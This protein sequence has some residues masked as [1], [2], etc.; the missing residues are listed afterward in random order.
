VIHL[1][2]SSTRSNSTNVN[3]K[4][5]IFVFV[6]R[7]KSW[8]IHSPIS[9]LPTSR[10]QLID[11]RALNTRPEFILNL[12]IRTSCQQQISHEDNNELKSGTKRPSTSSVANKNVY[13]RVSEGSTLP[14]RGKLLAL[15]HRERR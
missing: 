2:P 4:L 6:N 10:N 8:F 1:R 7:I 12:V 9:A 3:N 14:Q 15:Q 13:K 5:R 11:G